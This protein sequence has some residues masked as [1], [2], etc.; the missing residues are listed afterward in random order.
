MT[1]SRMCYLRVQGT[2]HCRPHQSSIAHLPLPACLYTL[3][4][5]PPKFHLAP[6]SIW[7]RIDRGR[8]S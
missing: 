8:D 6:S 4:A 7:L 3:D 2:G 5:A 1:H